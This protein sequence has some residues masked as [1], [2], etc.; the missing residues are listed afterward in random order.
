MRKVKADH[1]H[2]GLDQAPEHFFAFARWTNCC[3]NLCSFSRSS[4]GT[5]SVPW[6]SGASNRTGS[7]FAV[8]S[9]RFAVRSSRLGSSAIGPLPTGNCERRTVNRELLVAQR[10]SLCNVV[11]PMEA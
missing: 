3:D 8:R 5:H 4:H 7:Q 2:T 10:R 11:G 9:S 6:F 1:V